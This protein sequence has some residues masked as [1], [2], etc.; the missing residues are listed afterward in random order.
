[1]LK[2]SICSIFVAYNV[3]FK[4]A[5]FRQGSA[6]ISRSSYAALHVFSITKIGHLF[7]ALFP[8]QDMVS[9]QAFH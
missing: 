8:T 3:V 5:N 7:N 1:M 2:Y 9:F 4:Q 6:S